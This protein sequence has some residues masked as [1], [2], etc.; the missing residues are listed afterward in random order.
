MTDPNQNQESTEEI[1]EEEQKEEQKPLQTSLYESAL[2]VV[3]MMN[4][5][6]NIRREDVY[7]P[8]RY[9]GD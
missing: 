1:I 7:P 6:T 9:H 8:G 2:W 5:S 3:D 4:N